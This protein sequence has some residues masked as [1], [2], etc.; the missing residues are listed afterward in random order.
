MAE[1]KPAD[2]LRD[3]P[4]L[5]WASVVPSPH[6]YFVAV[7]YESPNNLVNSCMMPV[8][9]AGDIGDRHLRLR[10]VVDRIVP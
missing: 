1:Q 10:E 7:E 4:S 9:L 8:S 3:L 2:L 6:D 5:R